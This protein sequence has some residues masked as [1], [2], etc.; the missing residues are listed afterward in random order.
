MKSSNGTAMEQMR[1]EHTRHPSESTTRTARIGTVGG[2]AVAMA[3]EVVDGQ[4]PNCGSPRHCHRPAG[5]PG[6]VAR[7]RRG[8]SAPIELDSA[9]AAGADRPLPGCG[10]D[11]LPT[12]HVERCPVVARSPAC[13]EHAKD[14][15][16]I[17]GA[18][19]HQP[20]SGTRSS[21]NLPPPAWPHILRAAS[22]QD[23]PADT[24]SAGLPRAELQC[25]LARPCSWCHDHEVPPAAWPAGA[26]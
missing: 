25:D 13:G 7:V 24:C 18:Q 19:A 21:G 6:P 9:G 17:W 1:N 23:V 11:T 5:P 8:T 4:G 12:A 3:W 10:P 16:P 20:R 15:V 26:R 22:A 14:L 2:A